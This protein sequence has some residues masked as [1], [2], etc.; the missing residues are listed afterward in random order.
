[1]NASLWGYARVSSESQNLDRQ[2][3]MLKAHGVEDR[4][5]KTEKK[6]GKDF[7]RPEFL[8]LVGT[9]TVA[10]SMR[11]GDC[12]VICSLDRLGRNYNEIQYYW[13]HITQELKCDIVVLDMPMLDTRGE[14]GSLDKR[15]VADLVLQ[16]LSYVAEKERI[17]I[18]TR[19][20]QGIDAAKAKGIKF[21][22]PEK[23]KPEGFDEIADKWRRGE[24]TATA[25]M[26]KLKL[27]RYSFYKFI[28]EDENND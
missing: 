28:K 26:G 18:H 1:M 5:I 12:L 25:A 24:I 6:S 17:S 7:E 10:P 2:I 19:Q 23:M 21:G 8:S 27:S 3:E 22:R 14:E 20:R 15:F 11:E 9:D 13:K 16:I 4:Y